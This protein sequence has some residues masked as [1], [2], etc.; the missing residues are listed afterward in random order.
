VRWIDHGGRRPG[1]RFWTLDPIDG[2]KGFLRRGHYAVALAL[3]E[4]GRV[5]L[6]ALACPELQVD[7]LN[8]ERGRGILCYALRGR[9]AWLEPLAG[10]QPAVRLRTDGVRDLR[11]ARFVES[12]ESAHTDQ[13]THGRIAE[14]L[15]IER[16][17]LR[18]D[19]QA[20]YAAIAR[21]E[22]SI[23]LRLPSPD[24]PDYR[25]RLWD[26]AAGAL[27]VEEAGGVVSDARGR[28]LDFNRGA[29][30]EQNSGVVA[31]SGPGHTAVVRACLR[32]QGRD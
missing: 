24:T 32:V 27:L 7:P 13:Q 19:S 4:A 17:P 23:Y 9:G 5:V 3:L 31:T 16:Q 22:A 10:R 26:H 20:K 25:E 1:N 11:A 2:T 12:V 6:G 28:P 30:L 8:P 15:G 14:L 21:G 18:M 29:R